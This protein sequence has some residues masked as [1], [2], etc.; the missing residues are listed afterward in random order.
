MNK[1]HFIYDPPTVPGI[2]MHQADR[3][4]DRILRLG[5]KDGR[6][7]GTSWRE[8]ARNLKIGVAGLLSLG[9]Q[10]GDAIGIISRTRAEWTDAD[11]SILASGGVVIGIYPTASMWEM[12]HII[13]HSGL[14]FCFV[15]NDEVLEK[16]LSIRS[17]LGIPEVVIV[18]ETWQKVLPNAVFTMEDLEARGR[19]LDAREPHRFD[20]TW[21][22]VRPEDLATIAYT[23]GTTGPPKGAMITHANLYFTA[24]NASSVHRYEETDFG[25]GFLPLTHMLQRLS[26]YAAIHLGIQGAY[27]ESIDKLVD[28]FREL[29]PTV[30]VSVP[31]IFDRIYNRIHQ[32]LAAGPPVRKKIFDWALS[33]GKQTAPYHMSGRKIPAWLAFKQRLAQRLVFRKVHDVFGGRV[34]YLLCG[35]APT[36]MYLLEFFYAAGLLILEGYGL[37]ET[38]A[39]ATINRADHF[40][41]GTVGQL[42]PGMEA[43]LAPDGELLLK[44]KGLFQ[45]YFNDPEATAAAIDAGGWFHT[46]DIAMIDAE[47]FITIT[48][49]KKDIIVS[50]GGKNIAPQNIEGLLQALPIVSRAMVCGEGRKY[51]TALFTLDETECRDFATRENIMAESPE[52]L[53]QH[54]RIREFLDEHV[55][56][57]NARL[58]PYERIQRF[59]I[60]LEDFTE[61][62]GEITPTL[63]IRRREIS[64]K[65]SSLIEAMY[66]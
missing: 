39:P 52:A 31:Q 44:G 26:T 45:G 22:S 16:V 47:G 3:Y 21:R 25:I 38:V 66:N 64:N 55:Q 58:A 61:E 32:M 53:K 57:V 51:L 5:K 28:N 43:K 6:W 13:H 11:M 1:S 54:S 33:V 15:E 24:L 23:S 8:A 7:E 59:T 56:A 20:S 42:I 10:K 36:P 4:G 34:K 30:Q 40:K 14:R 50:T 48:D 18:F 60:L 12:T 62:G 17:S 49:R 65:Y 37:T 19:E 46:G 35:G 63:K 27:A 41:F 9:L 29:R 2:F